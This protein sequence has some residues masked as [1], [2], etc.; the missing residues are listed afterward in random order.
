[1]HL[2]FMMTIFTSFWG[3]SKLARVTTHKHNSM[4]TFLLDGETLTPEQIFHLGEHPE[5][6]ID[7][8][9][10]AWGAV[11]RARAVVD[12]VL[13]RREVSARF[14]LIDASLV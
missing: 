8:S 1:M 2:D 11:G 12:R 7:L 14:K 5:V 4:A 10:T 9:P 6:N 13:A 3:N